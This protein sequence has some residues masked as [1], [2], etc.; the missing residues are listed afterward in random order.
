MEK[1]MAK[2]PLYE[3][4]HRAIKPRL[5]FGKWLLILIICIILL[6]I[7]GSFLGKGIVS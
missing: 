3:T 4:I 7:I 2:S 1:K 5:Q 6:T